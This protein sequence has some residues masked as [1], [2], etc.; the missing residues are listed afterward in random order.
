MTKPEDPPWMFYAFGVFFLGAS[1]V[2]GWA[3]WSTASFY[4]D[5]S[6]RG[7]RA[8]ANILSYEE[9]RQRF[10]RS[11][12]PVFRF[13]TEDGR[14]VRATSGV[15]TE[16]TVAYSPTRVV[17]VVYDPMDPSRVAQAEAVEGKQAIAYVGFPILVVLCMLGAGIGLVLWGRSMARARPA[18]RGKAR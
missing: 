11:W 3:G 5:L 6:A 7:V 17:P 4:W 12:R 2:V 1:V 13:K 9:S 18:R 14:V 10:G 8:E 15:S 16:T